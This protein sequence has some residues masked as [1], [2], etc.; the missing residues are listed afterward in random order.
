MHLRRIDMSKS[1]SPEK[2]NFWT[3]QPTVQGRLRA[4]TLLE[5]VPGTLQSFQLRRLPSLSS[6]SFPA[7]WTDKKI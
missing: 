5:L 1:S 6:G 3:G 2:Y 4:G 7:T